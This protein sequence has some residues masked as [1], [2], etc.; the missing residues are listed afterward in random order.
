MNHSSWSWGA[1]ERRD[2]MNAPRSPTGFERTPPG[3]WGW[4]NIDPFYEHPL[5]RGLRIRGALE[6]LE[7]CVL[8][9]ISLKL[10]VSNL[11]YEGQERHRFGIGKKE[12]R[13]STF[14]KW[15]DRW[16]E[17]QDAAW[18]RKLIKNLRNFTEKKFGEVGCVRWKNERRDLSLKFGKELNAE[19]MIDTMLEAKEQWELVK[20]YVDSIMD[21]KT[22]GNEDNKRLGGFRSM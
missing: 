11:M 2:G 4:Q 10:K 8:V 5:H 21:R 15:Q 17:A 19:N 6:H 3:H 18:T 16:E 20:S 7:R 9:L 1:E 13:E 12:L 22:K 14:R